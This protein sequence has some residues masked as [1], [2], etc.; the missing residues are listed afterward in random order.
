[1]SRINKTHNFLEVGMVAG[2]VEVHYLIAWR[3]A[4]LSIFLHG[5]QVLVRRERSRHITDHPGL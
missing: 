5:L 3:E 4:L 2:E 1:M